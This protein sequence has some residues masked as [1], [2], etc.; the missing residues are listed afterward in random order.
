MEAVTYKPNVSGEVAIH[1]VFEF[2][3]GSDGRVGK[4]VD[5]WP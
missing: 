3:L 4:V 1:T 5:H 2:S